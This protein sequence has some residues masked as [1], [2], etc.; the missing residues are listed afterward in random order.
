VRL[1]I[2]SFFPGSDQVTFIV[3]TLQLKQPE[4]ETVG[5]EIRHDALNYLAGDEIHLVVPGL[6]VGEEYQFRVTVR[7]VFGSSSPVLSDK[8]VI[9]GELFFLDVIFENEMHVNHFLGD[10]KVFNQPPTS[11]PMMVSPFFPQ[12]LQ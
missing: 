2:R 10:V 3:V 12:K 4:V 11:L 9:V 1:T 6:S 7:N 5:E 8:I